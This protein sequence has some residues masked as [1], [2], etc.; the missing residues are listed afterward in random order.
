MQPSKKYNSRISV[1]LIRVKRTTR[2]DYM[3]KDKLKELEQLRDASQKKDLA[4]PK[5]EEEK[6]LHKHVTDIYKKISTLKI[7]KEQMSFNHFDGTYAE[8]QKYIQR[9]DMAIARQEEYLRDAEDMLI[10]Y[11]KEIQL[12]DA[13]LNTK[14]EKRDWLRAFKNW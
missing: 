6:L 8:Y 4:L 9:L 7:R 14:D 1:I 2:R 12:E 13:G 3:R 5:Q 10:L 11:N